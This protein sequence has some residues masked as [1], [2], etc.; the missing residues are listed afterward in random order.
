M[1]KYLIVN[2]AHFL[3]GEHVS[4]TNLIGED[5]LTL[6]AYPTRGYLVLK[7]GVTIIKCFNQLVDAH[8]YTPVFYSGKED[9]SVIITRLESA[10][11]VKR[12][13]LPKILIAKSPIR[14]TKD[15]SPDYLV[16]DD[17]QQHIRSAQEKGYRAHLIGEEVTL[18]GALQDVLSHFTPAPSR[19][20][21]SSPAYNHTYQQRFLRPSNED[22]HSV[23]LA[24]NRLSEE[25]IQEINDLIT[26]LDNEMG[27]CYSPNKAIKRVKYLALHALLAYN[28]TM[29][30]TEAITAIEDDPSRAGVRSGCF[31]RTANLFDRLKANHFSENRKLGL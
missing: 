16:F 11:A 30:V 14:F 2:C 3:S 13:P 8:G 4:D 19:S 21:S 9:A 12:L 29:D 10:C 22:L 24:T 7:E 5:D 27:K 15:D 31:S 26:R 23:S 18:S 6:Y 20:L 28:E 17:N 25:E 1:P